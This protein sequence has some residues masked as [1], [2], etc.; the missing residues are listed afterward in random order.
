MRAKA[1]CFLFAGAGLC[2][3]ALAYNPPVDTAGPLR[4]LEAQLVRQEPLAGKTAAATVAEN[5]PEFSG[6]D[7]SGGAVRLSSRVERGRWREALS[8]RLGPREC[9]AGC[10][11]AKRTA[12][13]CSIAIR[14]IRV[15]ATAGP[16][17]LILAR[18][19]R[20]VFR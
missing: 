20:S 1:L 11:S 13:S 18:Q 14:G 12:K 4:R 17:G 16:P 7:R 15:P 9:C 3:A 5:T 19:L 6:P 2:D 10:R 8:M